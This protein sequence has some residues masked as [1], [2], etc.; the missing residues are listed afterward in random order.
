LRYDS[1]EFWNNIK[2]IIT[3]L[4]VDAATDVTNKW[5]AQNN[6]LGFKF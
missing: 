3:S 1:R 5:I 4:N 6:Q 2:N